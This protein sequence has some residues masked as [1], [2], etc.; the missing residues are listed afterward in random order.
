MCQGRIEGPLWVRPP[1]KSAVLR[2][3]LR[4]HQILLRSQNCLGLKTDAQL[5]ELAFSFKVA[6]AFACA[7]QETWRE[8]TEAPFDTDGVSFILSGPKVQKGRG[9][10]G[11]GFAL[12]NE[13]FKVWEMSGSVMVLSE[14]DRTMG[15]RF[16]M[17]DSD[18]KDVGLFLV[19]CYAPIGVAPQQE[20]E[21]FLA[22]WDLVCK[23]AHS[24][25]NTTEEDGS[26]TDGSEPE[27][28]RAR[29]SAA[30]EVH[31]P[32]ATNSRRATRKPVRYGTYEKVV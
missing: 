7:L 20:W 10:K 28:R 19:C 5:R 32:R 25:D 15:I 13:A 27:E 29:V 1:S 3:R 16:V 11:I 30:S 31:S 14:D 23:S 26:E 18:G 12:S 6:G 2:K 9:T 4:I 21:E 22:G 8:G 17:K 24:S